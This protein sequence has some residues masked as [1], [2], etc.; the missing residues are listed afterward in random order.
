MTL[1]DQILQRNVDFLSLNYEFAYRSLPNTCTT[2]TDTTGLNKSLLQHQ[3]K[4]AVTCQEMNTHQDSSK[5]SAE[6][7]G[8]KI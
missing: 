7:L 5:S 4:T 8:F 3:D 2:E 1:Q 6:L